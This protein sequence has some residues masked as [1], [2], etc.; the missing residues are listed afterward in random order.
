MPANPVPALSAAQST[1]QNVSRKA[2]SIPALAEVYAVVA[3]EFARVNALIPVL[4]VLLA[5]R[6]TAL[7]DRRRVT[8]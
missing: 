4:S 6:M 2:A 1:A 3:D 5:I 7:R 8:H